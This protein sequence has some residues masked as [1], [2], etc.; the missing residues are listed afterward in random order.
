MWY[1]IAWI[2]ITFATTA[3]NSLWLPL[4][5]EHLPNAL[6]Q[7]VNTVVVGGISMVIFFPI[8][9]IVFPEGEA[10]KKK[11]EESKK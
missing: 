5:A 4:A 8:F 6:Y 7:I 3:L 11:K 2:L 1:F 10:G 9:K